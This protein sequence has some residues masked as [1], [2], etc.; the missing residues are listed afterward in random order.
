[1]PFA[2]TSPNASAAFHGNFNDIQGNQDNRFSKTIGTIIGGNQNQ[3]Y[4]ATTI[5]II[6]IGADSDPVAKP[7][8]HHILQAVA[9]PSNKA[10]SDTARC[11][12]QC[13]QE[14]AIAA[15]DDASGLIVS[16]IR[17][18]ASRTES[19][20]CYRDLKLSLEQLN[21]TIL[22][23]RL[24]LQIFGHT[25]LGRSFACTIKPAILDCRT[26]LQE[27]FDKLEGYLNLTCIQYLWRVLWSGFD[28]QELCLI[29]ETLGKQQVAL[30]EFLISWTELGNELLGDIISLHEFQTNLQ[31]GPLRPQC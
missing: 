7:S 13:W 9:G 14:Q 16:I 19:Y 18:L 30:R 31:R 24:A 2:Q 27:L 28:D 15:A 11:P 3:T 5:N 20:G 8:V 17:L 12:L 4:H 23:S 25:P 29:K 22:M 6:I 26:V 1:M 21:H 10:P